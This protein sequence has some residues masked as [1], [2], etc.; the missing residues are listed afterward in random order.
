MKLDDFLRTKYDLWKESNIG[1][2]CIQLTRDKERAN[3]IVLPSNIKH[4]Y[5]LGERGYLIGR[6]KQLYNETKSMKEWI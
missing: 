4:F 5:D 2:V 3:I 6:A 1:G